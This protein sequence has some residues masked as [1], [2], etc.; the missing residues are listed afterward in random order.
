MSFGGGFAASVDVASI[1]GDLRALQT[2]LAALE[3]NKDKPHDRDLKKALIMSGACPPSLRACDPDEQAKFGLTCPDARIYAPD[4]L[5]ADSEGRICYAP[6]DLAAVVGKDGIG[7][8]D[9]AIER[10][11][12]LLLR[13]LDDKGALAAVKTKLLEASVSEATQPRLFG[14]SACKLPQSDGT[15]SAW[16]PSLVED[17]DK[18]AVNDGLSQ[19]VAMWNT[20]DTDKATKWIPDSLSGITAQTLRDWTTWALGGKEG[21]G[22]D[23]VF[24]GYAAPWTL[25]V[26]GTRTVSNKANAYNTAVNPATLAY[27]GAYAWAVRA[28]KMAKRLGGEFEAKYVTRVKRLPGIILACNKAVYKRSDRVAALATTYPSLANLTFDVAWPIIME[29]TIGL[30]G[31]LRA[32]NAVTSIDNMDDDKFKLLDPR[33]QWDLIVKQY[34]KESRAF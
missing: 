1:M 18:E 22:T 4:P 33:A 27:A 17:I 9:S 12:S 19:A 29:R 7:D 20:K 15:C 10:L 6:A 34:K 23:Y 32:A 28:D 16:S 8:L 2:R 21:D 13:E 30:K 5:I 24:H 26:Q 14:M 3:T 11:S 31:L 25:T